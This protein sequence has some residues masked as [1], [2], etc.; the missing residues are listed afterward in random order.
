ME[1]IS[2]PIIFFL[3]GLA[4]LLS[5]LMSFLIIKDK[6]LKPLKQLWIFIQVFFLCS[7]ISILGG[8]LFVTLLSFSHG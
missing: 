4:G 7:L 6:N 5:L 3:G 1:P 2:I 8:I